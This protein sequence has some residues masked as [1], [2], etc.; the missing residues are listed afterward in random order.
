MLSFNFSIYFFT[1][2]K[3]SEEI[4]RQPI[5]LDVEEKPAGEAPKFTKL[6][7]DILVDEGEKVI[8]ECCVKGDPEPDIRWYLN[9]QSVNITERTQVNNLQQ[10]TFKKKIIFKR[11]TFFF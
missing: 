11:L 2:V 4:E 8:L 1:A 3:D 5:N 7:T 10:K 9:N 6:L